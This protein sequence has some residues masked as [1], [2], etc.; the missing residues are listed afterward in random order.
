[1]DGSCCCSIDQAAQI[2]LIV[3]RALGDHMGK[4]ALFGL[5][6]NRGAMYMLFFACGVLGGIAAVAF[7]PGA[8]WSSTIEPA[9][10]TTAEALDLAA[11]RSMAASAWW[12]VVIAAIGSVVGG[13]SLFLILH[14][15]RAAQRSAIATEST[16]AET[17]SVGRAQ[18]RAYVSIGEI[19]FN[20]G[21]FA[22]IAVELR[23][24]G[25]SP[26]RSVNIRI[27]IDVLLID[28]SDVDVDAPNFIETYTTEVRPLLSGETTIER[29][30]TWEF[31]PGQY[32]TRAVLLGAEAN[33]TFSIVVS[34]TDVFGE[35]W[36]EEASALFLPNVRTDLDVPIELSRFQ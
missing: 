25:Q 11:Q 14:T 35:R 3:A 31:N 12:M 32:V 1:M 27:V 33:F 13:L 19:V 17:R 16:V 8:P 10:A 34:F 26:A 23:N 20:P 2:F 36:E 6:V 9:G 22:N 15:L 29:V 4:R 24:V 28:M 5:R 18:T 7:T 21:A 30:P